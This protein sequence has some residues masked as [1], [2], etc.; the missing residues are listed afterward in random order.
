M[1]A[2]KVRVEE[3]ELRAAYHEDFEDQPR[4][5][6][7]LHLRHLL[8]PFTGEGAD[9]KRAACATAERARARLVAGEPFDVVA[10]Q[11]TDKVPGSAD[12]GWIHEAR[13]AS[14][15]SGKVD[16]AAPGSVTEVIQTDFGCNVLQV[17]DRRPYQAKGFDEVKEQLHQRLFAERM[18][19]EYLK[20]M[21][22]LREQTYIE[23]KGIF[24]QTSPPIG[25]G[26]TGA[27]WST[28]PN[29]DPSGF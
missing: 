22:K 21:D 6:E 25:A 16:G 19:K 13:L 28:G 8:V 26:G 2:S 24:A 29:E 11:V 14:W 5:G 4:G 9:A 27:G 12:L 18:Q 17:V 3:A 7:E 10:S 1:V 20:F 15:M 23:R